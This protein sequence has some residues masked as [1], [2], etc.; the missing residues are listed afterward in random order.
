MEFAKEFVV[1]AFAAVVFWLLCIAAPELKH[2]ATPVVG[3]VHFVDG[4]K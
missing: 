2:R 4:R 3:A 1:M